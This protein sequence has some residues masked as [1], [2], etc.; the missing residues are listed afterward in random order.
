MF[1][2]QAEDGI[3]DLT[4]TGVQTC[5]LPICAIAK[6]RAACLGEA[7]TAKME[8]NNNKQPREDVGPGK[9]N[10]LDLARVRAKIAETKGPEYWRS[11]EELTGSEEFRDMLRREFPEGA[12]EWLDS[13]SRR[14]V[15]KLIGA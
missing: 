5:A 7:L 2:F 13:V 12:S 9:K 14:G 10:K 4:E 3:R 6:G 15:L 11:L 8:K 1:F